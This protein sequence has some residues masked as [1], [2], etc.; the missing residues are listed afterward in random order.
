[1]SPWFAPL[2][3]L[4]LSLFRLENLRRVVAVDEEPADRPLPRHADDAHGAVDPVAGDPGGAA[5]VHDV[6]AVVY[7]VLAVLLNDQEHR[8]LAV[9]VLGAD[10]G[11]ELAVRFTDVVPGGVPDERLATDRRQVRLPGRRALLA[12]RLNG[13]RLGRKVAENIPERND[14]GRRLFQRQGLLFLRG[15]EVERVGNSL[16]TRQSVNGDSGNHKAQ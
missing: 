3:C 13:L 1:M 12:L 7:H 5:A 2:V 10:V 4:G 11:R 15:H 6:P 16:H 14:L 8:H 9:D